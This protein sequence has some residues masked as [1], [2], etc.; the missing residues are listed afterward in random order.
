MQSLKRILVYL[1][2]CINP[3]W[4]SLRNSQ[5][6][7]LLSETIDAP[8]SSANV[9][10]RVPFR[11]NKISPSRGRFPSFERIDNSRRP[12]EPRRD[13]IAPSVAEVK[14]A[15]SEVQ[16]VVRKEAQLDR[17]L[18]EQKIDLPNQNTAGFGPHLLTTSE[19]QNIAQQSATFIGSVARAIEKTQSR[20]ATLSRSFVPNKDVLSRIPEIPNLSVQFRPFC[21]YNS[22]PSCQTTAKYRTA[23]GTCNNLNNPLW[24]RSQTPFERFVF[25]FYEDDVQDPRSRDV[26]G[27]PLP[28]P[29]EISIA[30]HQRST[31]THVMDLSQF[32]MEFGQ[33]VSHDIQFNALSKGYL[34]SNLNC[35]DRKGLNRLN[36]LPI[37]LPKDDPYFASFKRT[38]MNFVRSLPSAALDCSV[39]PRQQINQNTH[40]IDGSAVYGSDQNTMNS[41]R[42]KRDGRLQ[43]HQSSPVLNSKTTL[44]LPNG[45]LVFPDMV[46]GRHGDHLVDV[47][48]AD[49]AIVLH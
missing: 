45:I 12:L 43:S 39:G 9:P 29:R 4:T 21:P 36:C 26:N 41:L 49:H 27:S 14:S 28:G 3:A 44:I 48:F 16:S 17:Q 35:C 8:K 30:V 13:S 6:N 1:L 38:C 25:P 40:Y 23:D 15:I 24:G 47:L 10:S 18:F 20:R 33:F 42:L 46:D 11:E 19:A 37:S 34:N 32:T 31:N 2:L 7:S 5:M 22:K